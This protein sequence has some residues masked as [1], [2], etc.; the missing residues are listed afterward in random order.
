MEPLMTHLSFRQ[1]IPLSTVFEKIRLVIHKFYS[2][3][4]IKYL[5]E[6]KFS[7]SPLIGWFLDKNGPT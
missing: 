1:T 4:C 5:G 3:I 6:E 2:F 7:F